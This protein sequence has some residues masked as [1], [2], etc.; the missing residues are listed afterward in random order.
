MIQELKNAFAPYGWILT[1]AVSPGKS[2]IDSA[3]DIPSLAKYYI[4]NTNSWNRT[5]YIMT[6]SYNL[7]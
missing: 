2:T 6:I 5:N 7:L 1:A 3:Y 4:F